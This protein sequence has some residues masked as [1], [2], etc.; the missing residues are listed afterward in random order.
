MPKVKQGKS[1]VVIG[2]FNAV[3]KG[4][5]KLIGRAAE[6]AKLKNLKTVVFTFDENL[7]LHKKSLSFLSE[8]KRKELLLSLGADEI[9]V[10]KFNKSF[11]AL[12]PEGFVSEILVKKLAAAAVVVGENFH[13]GKNA[14]GDAKKLRSLCAEYGLDCHILDLEKTDGG[15]IIS[16]SLIKNLAAQGRVDEVYKYCGRPLTISGVVIHGREEGRQIGFPTVNFLLPENV[17]VPG[18]GVY[19]SQVTLDNKTYPAITN[20]GSAPTFDSSE[21]LA[22]THIIGFEKDLYGK[23]IEVSL[24]KKLRDI[25]KFDSKEKLINQLEKDKEISV[26]INKQKK[27]RKD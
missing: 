4:H 3:H 10:Q 2:G 23:T 13:F 14:S 11:M 20:I 21:E 27:F 17:V 7:G 15:V 8:K 22:E 25:E 24:I 19:C 18:R 6:I 26:L 5:A 1:V 9:Y 12:S 16:S